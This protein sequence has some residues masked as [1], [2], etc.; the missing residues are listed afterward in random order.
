VLKPCSQESGWNKKCYKDL[1]LKKKTFEKTSNQ[2]I[3]SGLM[4]TLEVDGERAQL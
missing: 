3:P 1:G 2:N 4:I